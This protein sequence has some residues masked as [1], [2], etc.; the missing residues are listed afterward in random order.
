M[1][2]IFTKFL[3]NHPKKGQK[4][5]STAHRNGKNALFHTFLE[6]PKSPKYVNSR[7]FTKM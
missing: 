5:P 2:K 6:I 7:K 3:K 4:T 1:Y